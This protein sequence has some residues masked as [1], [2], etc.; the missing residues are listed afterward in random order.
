MQNLFK[1]K[2]W[3]RAKDKKWQRANGEGPKAK[4]LVIKKMKSLSLFRSFALS[5]LPLALS[6][7]CLLSLAGPLVYAENP[8]PFAGDKLV[9]HPAPE[10]TLK[11]VT[12]AAFSL[13]AYKGRVVLLNFWATWCP[14]CREEMPS[15]NKL[16]Q[17][18]KSRKFSIIAVAADR[19]VPDV[20]AFLKDRPTDFTVLLDNSLFVSKSLY[21]VFV[22]PTSYLIDKEGVIVQK[23]YGEED[24]SDPELV[25]KIESL[26]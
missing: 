20:T 23:F 4:G 11:D 21:K 24:W 15:M 12:G 22:L 19:S 18:L 2:I 17:Q 5:L 14:S 3:R 6:L 7:F 13:S 8:S 16:S 9:N 10:F 25:K 1:I 26:F